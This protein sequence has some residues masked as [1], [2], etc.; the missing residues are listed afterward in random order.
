MFYIELLEFLALNPVLSF[1][2]L[3]AQFIV[4]MKIHH[5]AHNKYLH[6]A[7]GLWFLP[8]NAVV[9]AVLFTIV[10]ME[11]PKE[12]TVTARMKRWKELPEGSWRNTWR[13]LVATKLCDALN[14]ADAGHC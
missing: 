1:F 8:Q 3:G 12:W 9:N 7:L 13:I 6:K 5:K 14:W 2:I 4:V 11:L 10:G